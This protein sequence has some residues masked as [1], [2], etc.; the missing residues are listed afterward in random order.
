VNYASGT[1]TTTLTFTYTVASG[2]NSIDLEYVNTTS[3]AL[4]G[5]T[6]RDAGSNNATLTLPVVGG[7]GSLGNNKAIIVD[8]TAPVAVTLLTMTPAN[9][10]Y[11]NDTT[12]TISSTGSTE[13]NATVLVTN[14]TNSCTTT[15]NGSGDWSCTISPAFATDGAKALTVTQ[16]D[17][18]GNVSVGA[19]YTLNVDTS[20]PS[21]L[22]TGGISPATGSNVIDSTPTISGSAGNAEASATIEVKQG[23][24]TLCTTTSA[25]DG[26]WS[27]TTTVLA[28]GTHNMTITQ[29]DQANNTSATVAYVLTIDTAAPVAPD[30]AIASDTGVSTTD[31]ITTDST[32]TIS[33][34]CIEG[35][36]AEIEV[37][38]DAVLNQTIACTTGTSPLQVTLAALADGAH[39]ITAV[40][41]DNLGNSSAASTGLG[42]TIDTAADG[43]TSTPD[44][45]AGTDS[46]ITTDGITNDTT[47][48]FDITCVTG[49]T[50]N[51]IGSIDGAIGTGL[52]AAGTVTIT[53]SVLSQGSQNITATQTDPAGNTSLS[54]LSLAV[55]ID[56]VMTI[57]GTAD[58]QTASD[59]G[60]STTD[61]IS[62]DTTPSFNLTCDTG[63]T[64]TIYVNGVADTS[65]ACVAGTVTLTLSALAAPT[66]T[67]DIFLITADSVDTAGNTS[68]LN[69]AL[70]ITIDT[71][72]PSALS[73]IDIIPA[74]PASVSSTPLLA[75]G[76]NAAAGAIITIKEAGLT[77]CT[78]V[79]DGT[80]AWSCSI[81]QTSGAHTYDVTQSDAAGNESL[82]IVYSATYSP[83]SSSGGGGGGSGGGMFD[84]CSNIAGFQFIT[85]T[86]YTRTSS[87]TCILTIQI[88]EPVT[89]TPVTTPT[90]ETTIS[91]STQN[92]PSTIAQAFDTASK[93]SFPGQY[94]A[95]INRK[96]GTQAPALPIRST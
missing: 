80:G 90:K 37:Y 41:T 44:M 21:A 3:L 9:N 29:T 22:S 51:L 76:I 15:A 14:G 52:C 6:I 38:V 45:T 7:V 43:I 91:S 56:S 61:N 36:N 46:N 19:T 86:G 87:G 50:V 95:R 25:V 16:T 20:I 59:T 30:L 10:G 72:T 40:N 77:V 42:I 92:I 48:N 81:T 83:V 2:E 89:Q 96:R 79:A 85:P 70:S 24:T 84:Y 32:P 13:A 4:N 26:S 1:G 33:F 34:A 12:P 93:R 31:N 53:S 74:S 55:T 58:M 62:S 68:A 82:A 27:C 73:L 71:T 65:G 47:P 57:P 67:G 69:A 5:G 49:S 8:T 78:A 75:S 64:V 17:T 54:S 28:D 35:V 39:T 63:S 66:A 18:A 60:A 88:S 11:T 94:Q 23:A